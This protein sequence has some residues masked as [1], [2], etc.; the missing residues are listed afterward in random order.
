MTKKKEITSLHHPS[1]LLSLLPSQNNSALIVLLGGLKQ[2]GHPHARQ[3]CGA[4]ME[5]VE[6]KETTM[7]ER[8]PA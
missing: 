1:I 8:S 4:D 7:Q 5:S 6:T 3:D 2:A